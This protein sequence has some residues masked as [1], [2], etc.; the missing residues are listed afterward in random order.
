MQM[1]ISHQPAR[2]EKVKVSTE[3]TRA[4]LTRDQATYSSEI[5]MQKSCDDYYHLKYLMHYT[6]C[7]GPSKACAL[8]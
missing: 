4:A 2:Q 6:H 7:F 8:W 5:T 3:M 1:R